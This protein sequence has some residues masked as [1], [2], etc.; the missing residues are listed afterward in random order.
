MWIKNYILT[1]IIAILFSSF[2]ETLMPSS[3]MKKHISLISGI[4][5]ILV[6]IKPIIKLPE[7][8]LSELSFR[9]EYNADNYS[10]ALKEKLNASQE[11]I[12]ID[13]FETALVCRIQKD[14]KMH[15]GKK[16]EIVISTNAQMVEG[17]I[18]HGEKNDDIIAYIKSTYGIECVFD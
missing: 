5:M 14:L 2:V 1:I 6:I 4:I 7:Y 10:E 12:I 16:Y 9:L 13:D 18:L 11:K 8:M 3:N 15:F 17:I